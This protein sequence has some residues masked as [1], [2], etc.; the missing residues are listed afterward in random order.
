MPESFTLC[1]ATVSAGAAD[2][3]V[4]VVSTD[5]TIDSSVLKSAGSVPIT[6]SVFPAA[7]DPGKSPGPAVT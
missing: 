4:A 3:P 5:T 1:A 7:F 2:G 6:D